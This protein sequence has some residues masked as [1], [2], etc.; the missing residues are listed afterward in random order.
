MCGKL[1]WSIKTSPT[2][3]STG[4]KGQEPIAGVELDPRGKALDV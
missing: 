1:L 2:V 4:V 3:S